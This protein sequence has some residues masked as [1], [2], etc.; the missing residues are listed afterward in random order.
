VAAKDHARGKEAGKS[1]ATRG[2][3]SGRPCL[4]SGIIDKMKEMH[5]LDTTQKE[6]RWQVVPGRL[7]RAV[8]SLTTAYDKRREKAPCLLLKKGRDGV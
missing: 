8:N 5:D 7:N 2:R 3:G 4:G 1:M 6:Y